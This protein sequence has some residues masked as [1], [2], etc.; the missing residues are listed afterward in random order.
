MI[1]AKRWAVSREALEYLLRQAPESW[2]ASQHAVAMKAGYGF[3]TAEA[4]R[5]P[6]RKVGLLVTW[7]HPNP[8]EIV[9]QQQWHD[10]PAEWPLVPVVVS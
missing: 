8:S 3:P 2:L 4:W 10:L 5:E 9:M 6:G 7:K 1:P